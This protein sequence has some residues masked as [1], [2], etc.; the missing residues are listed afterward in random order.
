[1][2]NK[3]VKSENKKGGSR[4]NTKWVITAVIWSMM[5]SGSTSLFSD[6]L[7]RKVNLLVAF[8]LLILI[9]IIGIMFDIIGV[10]VTAADEVPFHAMASKN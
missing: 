7:L 6:V 3:K 5:L 4:S 8:V 10:A 1:M 2:G 9:I